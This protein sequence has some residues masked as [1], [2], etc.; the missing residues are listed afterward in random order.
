[1]RKAGAIIPVGQS[2]FVREA[3]K[4]YTHMPNAAEIE[5]V[6]KAFPEGGYK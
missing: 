5:A 4:F 2:G 3:S 6:M 1:M